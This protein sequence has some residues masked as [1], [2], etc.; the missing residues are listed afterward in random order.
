MGDSIIHYDH[1]ETVGPLSVIFRPYGQKEIYS[2]KRLFSIHN[3]NPY[4]NAKPN[5]NPNPEP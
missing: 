3:A 2:A 1:R 4:T 5:T